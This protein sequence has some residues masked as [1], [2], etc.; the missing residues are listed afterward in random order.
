MRYAR[1]VCVSVLFDTM[2]CAFSRFFGNFTTS[3]RNF[4]QLCGFDLRLGLHRG[5]ERAAMT[6]REPTELLL[7]RPGVLRIAR[8]A[9]AR[10]GWY[11]LG[12]PA[13]WCL[14]HHERE[15]ARWGG[16]MYGDESP[17][18]ARKLVEEMDDDVFGARFDA[19]YNALQAAGASNMRHVK[20][21]ASFSDHLV[22]VARLLRVFRG[23]EGSLVLAGLG[24]TC[25]GSELFPAP[26]ASLADRGDM[27]RALG[28]T[29]ERLLYLYATTSQ[30]RWYR[31]VL[32]CNP[33][34]LAHFGED[35]EER[36]DA[37]R[38]SA[39]GTQRWPTATNFY[40]GETASLHGGE[41]A[42]LTLMHAAD[43]Y[44][45]LPKN[46]KRKS[47]KQ[48]EARALALFMVQEAEEMVRALAE[49]SEMRH[50]ANTKY[51]LM[52]REL[53]EY[54]KFWQNETVNGWREEFGFD[55][56]DWRGL[57]TA[58]ERLRRRRL[59]VVFVGYATGAL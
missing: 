29:T 51:H 35:A 53:S 36:P 24:H 18:T 47:A 43:V 38:Y 5:A 26:L 1:G 31:E 57:R 4:S 39:E 13:V 14:H 2:R 42:A 15:Y 10:A 25:Y 27:R 52:C 20:K 40:T 48:S 56:R 32:R 34:G 44:S 41:C 50:T 55:L 30:V 22:D 3:P 21:G 17:V 9:L 28:P 11:M 12:K 23:K 6:G 19:L 7:E 45:V 33:H 54:L 59:D 58:L 37:G 49:S 46:N 8:G 16:T